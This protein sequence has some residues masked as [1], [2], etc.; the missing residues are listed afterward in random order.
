MALA[1]FSKFKKERS[2]I[3]EARE[4]EIKVKKFNKMFAEKL[5][6]LNKTSV[7]DLSEEELNTFF[8]S[9]K[10]NPVNEDRMREIEANVI[11]AGKPQELGAEGSESESERAVKHTFSSPQKPEEQDDDEAKT[12]AVELQAESKKVVKEDDEEEDKGVEDVEAGDAEADK[13]GEEEDKGDAKVDSED[14]AEKKDHY[15][16]AVKSDDAEIEKD[17]AEI[18]DLK[19]DAEFD[20]KEE[21][22]EELEEVVEAAGLKL[23]KAIKA[24]KDAEEG[25]EEIMKILGASKPSE[26]TIYDTDSDGDSKEYK[27]LEKIKDWERIKA[28]EYSQYNVAEVWYNKKNNAVQTDSGGYIGYFVLESINEGKEIK[29]AA[30]FDKYADEVLKKA[31]PDDFDPKIAKKIKDGLKKKYG[32]D[33]GAAVGALTSGFGG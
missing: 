32:D 4:K 19:K 16:G 14:D 15:K 27:K 1:K 33:F 2:V 3:K 22:E 20:K 17:K 6:A 31:H 29:T 23:D 12:D 8:D 5:K 26:V 24:D 28:P 9:L 7:A 13:G 11:A 21:E 10:T 18:K 30:E 25:Y